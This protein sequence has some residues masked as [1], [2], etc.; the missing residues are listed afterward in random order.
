MIPKIIHYCWF[1]RNPLPPFAIK[2]I[3]SWKKYLPEY[4]IKE[5]NEDN[6]D[7]N[8]IPYT[9][10]AYET[11]KYA[12]V[13]DYARFWILYNYGGLYFDTD[14]EVIKNMD[15]IIVR[16][17]FMGCEKD[18]SDTTVASVVPGLDLGVNPGL[19]LGVNPGLGLYKEL[20]NEYAK[21]HFI[22]SDGS[23]NQKTIVAY[24][25]EILCRH[26]LKHTNQIQE[27][28]GVWIYPKEYFCPIDYNSGKKELTINTRTIHHYSATWKTSKQKYKHQL[29]RFL[30]PTIT[31]CMVKL[32]HLL[33]K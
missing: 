5:W 22:N 21:L 16:G 30:G 2:C 19:G 3:E 15:D 23:L 33:K 1:G 29:V 25:S 20:L 10:E 13:S 26:G 8:I 4:E 7:V 18:A 17:P 14:V 32:K 28:A 6:F 9:K 11:K 12:F 31:S 24:T 27:C